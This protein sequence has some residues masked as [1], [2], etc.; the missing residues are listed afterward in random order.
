MLRTPAETL[1]RPSRPDRPRE[2]QGVA[3]ADIPRARAAPP[4]GM[5]GRRRPYHGVQ[6]PEGA[7][8]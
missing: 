4:A 1:F 8:G 2:G 7:R 6:Q 5:A 3:G